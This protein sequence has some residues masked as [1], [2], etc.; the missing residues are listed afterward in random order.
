[1][2]KVLAIIISALIAPLSSA[3]TKAAE[4]QKASLVEKRTVNE[5]CRHCPD[6]NKTRY[7]LQ[8]QDGMIYVAETHRTLD[9]TL[10]GHN[11]LRVEKDGHVGAALHI[12][13]DAG[14][15]Q[16]L[17]IVGKIAPQ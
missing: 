12:L 2:I 7:S 4:W 1:M 15:E 3:Q 11:S 6:W 10:N 8:T 13:D 5:W 9:V 14:K 17:R 16:K